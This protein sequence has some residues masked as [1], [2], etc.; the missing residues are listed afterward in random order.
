MKYLRGLDG[1]RAVAI[2]L[3]MLFHFYYLLEV[4]WIGVQLFFVLS[5]YLI[6]SILLEDKRD[7]V[8]SF[9]LK[10]FYWRRSLR[11]FPLYYLYLLFVAIAFLIT[12]YPGDFLSTSP[13]LFT[14]TYNYFPLFNELNFDTLFTH[15]WSLSVEEQFYLIWPFI[16]F[17]FDK[18]VLKFVIGGI[19]LLSPLLRFAVGFVLEGQ[20]DASNIGEIIYRLTP[21]QLD[22]FAFGAAIPVFALDEKRW[23][24]KPL[25][26]AFLLLFVGV[27]LVN[28]LSFGEAKSISW[29]SL[30]FP[31]GAM[32]FFSHVWSYSLIN[33]LSLF[34]ILYT[35]KGDNNDLLIKLFNSKVMV[36]IGRV[37]YGLYVYHWVL[38]ALYRKYIGRMIDSKA[39][40]FLLFLLICYIVSY[41]SYRFFESRFISLKNRKFIKK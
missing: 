36:E 23:R 25:F 10:R 5:G 41:L 8:L 26:L 21:M 19:I 14:Y 27:G 35:I 28:M 17:F 29:S 30:G 18:R 15:F 40:S 16:I 39:L 31:I 2:L 13:F 4:G 22:G 38:F 7:T 33:L 32:D 3:V 1:V 11:V 20:F 12:G 24:F 6:T 9:Y 37:S 34:L